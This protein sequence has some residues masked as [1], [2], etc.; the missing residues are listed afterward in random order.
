MPT[1]AILVAAG[2][3]ALR[4]LNNAIGTIRL[5]VLTRD[6]RVLAFIFGFL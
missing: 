4:V 3:F 6:R 1:E 5:V 2:I